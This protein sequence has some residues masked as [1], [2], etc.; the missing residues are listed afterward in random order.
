MGLIKEPFSDIQGER[1]KFR[2]GTVALLGGS[3]VGVGDIA[4]SDPLSAVMCLFEHV[5]G[6]FSAALTALGNRVLSLF[7][8]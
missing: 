6:G 4:L 7:P 5:L 1:M 3:Q 8:E 2:R